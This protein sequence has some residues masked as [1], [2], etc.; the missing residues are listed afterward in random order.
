MIYKYYISVSGD[1][2]IP[3]KFMGKITGDFIIDSHF[4]STDKRDCDLDRTYDYGGISFWHP[5][6]FSTGENILDYE[7]DF[8]KFIEDNYRLF[9]E[10][11]ATDFEIYMEIY[12][13]GGQCN[14][15]IFSKILLKKLAKYSVSL[16]ISFYVLKIRQMKKWEKEVDMSWRK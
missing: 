16:P 8:V 2:L 5:N 11:S 10:N 1:N 13:D 15:E 7:N 3:E 14:F 6:K 4:K 12:S 9:I